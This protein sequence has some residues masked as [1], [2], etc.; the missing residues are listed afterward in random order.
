VAIR[1]AV[2]PV[3][4]G[5]RWIVATGTF[6]ALAVFA[7]AVAIEASPDPPTPPT[8]VS[9]RTFSIDNASRAWTG[10]G[11]VWIDADERGLLKIDPGSGRVVQTIHASGDRVVVRSGFVWV[12]D[13]RA[14]TIVRI[15]TSTGE[16]NKAFDL[17]MD[18]NSGADIS[19]SIAVGEGA[20]WFRTGNYLQR[21]D[22][23]GGDS[24]FRPVPDG[25]A[26]LAVGGGYVWLGAFPNDGVVS[27]VDPE[28]L[29][30]LA[31][32]P[33]GR[34]PHHI[35]FGDAAAWVTNTQDG[36]VSRVDPDSME[37]TDVIGVGG[38]PQGLVVHEGSV[39]VAD[40]GNTL[41]QIDTQSRRVVGTWTLQGPLYNVSASDGAIWTVGGGGV[42]TRLELG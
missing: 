29:T 30:V 40:A 6:L 5:R 24:A 14:Q 37:Q 25:A 15:D 10:H 3:K 19:D 21:F 7:L 18:P 41:W 27:K 1:I 26:G 16:V 33:V 20:V 36:T 35:A 39:W 11:E 31:T 9:I 23:S 38:S 4:R 32:T 22:L 17:Q 13:H 34:N 42:V 12:A 8:V 28:T 2:E